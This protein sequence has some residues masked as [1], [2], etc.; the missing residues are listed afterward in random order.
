MKEVRFSSVAVDAAEP[1]PPLLLLGSPDICGVLGGGVIR[2][3]SSWMDL[4]AGVSTGP[5]EGSPGAF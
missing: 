1:A 2:L 5:S 3:D 4:R